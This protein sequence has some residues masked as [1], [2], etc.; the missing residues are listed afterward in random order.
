MRIVFHTILRERRRCIA[1]L[2]IFKK[3]NQS[4]KLYLTRRV[5]LSREFHD[6][7]ITRPR[8]FNINF[9]AISYLRLYRGHNLNEQTDINSQVVNSTIMN[10]MAQ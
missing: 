2:Q 9:N 6:T 5:K 1:A 7:L 4:I 10:I 8:E 3:N